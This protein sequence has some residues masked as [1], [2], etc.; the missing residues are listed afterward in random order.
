MTIDIV[1]K[2]NECLTKSKITGIIQFIKIYTLY[3]DV[4]K[5]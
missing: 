1:S 5:L 2:L 4:H 3:M